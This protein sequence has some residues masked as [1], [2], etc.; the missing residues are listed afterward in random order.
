[1]QKSCSFFPY[2]LEATA[3]ASSIMEEELVGGGGAA[4][5]LN[6]QYLW[7][8]IIKMKTLN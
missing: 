2:Y 8:F 4:K 7:K 5:F 1:M 3:T 6:N